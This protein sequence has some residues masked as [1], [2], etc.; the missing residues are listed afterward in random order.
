MNRVRACRPALTALSVI[1]ISLFCGCTAAIKS[2]NA[3]SNAPSNAKSV[4]RNA[5]SQASN[6]QDDINIREPDRYSVAMTISG[7]NTASDAPASMATLQFGFAKFDADRRWTFTLPAPMGQV[8]YLEKSGLKYLVF[9]SSKQ[10]SEL[11]PD[12]LGFQIGGALS[13]VSIAQQMKSSV[14]FERL[15][16]EAV[17][18]RTAVEYRLTSKRDSS[19]QTEGVIFVDQETG[20][21][22]RSEASS[23][24]SNGKKWRV[25]VE[26][27]EIQLNPDRSQFDVPA[28]M[29]KVSQQE[30]KQQIESFG[31]VLRP[32]L[33]VMSGAPPAPIASQPAPN[34]NDGRNR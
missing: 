11:M 31:V 2:N 28:G 6:T 17:N 14:R 15:G 21:P 10:Y 18:G 1:I 8:A 12:A 20:L 30:A 4:N 16:T 29:K 13:P 5:D 33:D 19:T 22:L 24:Q 3:N 32:F 7:Q 34:K 9:L 26:E 25:I 27:R 23:T